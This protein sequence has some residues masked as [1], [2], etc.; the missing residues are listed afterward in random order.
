TEGPAILRKPQVRA[1][2]DECAEALSQKADV[3][4]ERVMRQIGHIA[5]SDIRKMFDSDGNLKSIHELDDATASAV[6]T[7][8]ALAADSQ[9]RGAEAEVLQTREI[10]L[11]DKVRALEM[12]A[13]IHQMYV[14][15]RETK[16][17]GLEDLLRD[18][19]DSENNTPMARLRARE[20]R[21]SVES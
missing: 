6:Q 16:H 13:K 18:I 10:K 8:R 2:L 4:E 17:A 21:G 5:F 3:T 7:V 19:Q 9:G 11:V 1:Y 14:E 20:Q 12:L 15:R